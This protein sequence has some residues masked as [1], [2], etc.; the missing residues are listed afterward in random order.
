VLVTWA[1]VS[2]AP[3]GAVSFAPAQRLLFYPEAWPTPQTLRLLA[4]EDG[5]V[6]GAGDAT[7]TLTAQVRFCRYRRLGI[8]WDQGAEG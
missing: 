1:L 3:H 4:E 5:L 7:L 8:Q 2:G 6:L